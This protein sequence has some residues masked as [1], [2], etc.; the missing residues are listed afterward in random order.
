MLTL[1]PKKK[2]RFIG[3]TETHG[4]GDGDGRFAEVELR[5]VTGGIAQDV[6][7]QVE[8]AVEVR[9]SVARRKR[10]KYLFFFFFPIQII[11]RIIIIFYYLFH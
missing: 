9:R 7:E 5:Q 1:K 8:S 10:Q 4:I 2:K 3:I 11:H 6:E